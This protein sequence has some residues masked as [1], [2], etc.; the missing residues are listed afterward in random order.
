MDMD[1][2]PRLVRYDDVM[3]VVTELMKEG[4]TG[5]DLFR[6]ITEIGHV[7]LDVLNEVMSKP[8]KAA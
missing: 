6:L 3:H 4:V 8:R 7:D 2:K 1:S 5:K